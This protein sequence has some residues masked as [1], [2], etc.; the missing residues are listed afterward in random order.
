MIKKIETKIESNKDSPNFLYVGV[1][2]SACGL[3]ALKKFLSNIPENNGMAF[4]IVQHM[5]PTH[6]SSLV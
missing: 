1:G 6:E 2:A 5:D 4:I 3:D